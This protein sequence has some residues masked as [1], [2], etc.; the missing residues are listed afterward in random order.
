M[1]IL[2]RPLSYVKQDTKSHVT[3]GTTVDIN[4]IG[5]SFNVTRD[6]SKI[7][8]KLDSLTDIDFEFNWALTR[9]IVQE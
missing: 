5:G 9:A 8:I 2:V 4:S 7:A 1:C 3:A 6:S